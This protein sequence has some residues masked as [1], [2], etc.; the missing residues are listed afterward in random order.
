M[1]IQIRVWANTS[2]RSTLVSPAIAPM[3]INN[4]AH[5]KPTSNMAVVKGEGVSNLV[6]DTIPVK[7]PA[8]RI[9]RTEEIQRDP[10]APRGKSF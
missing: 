10:M 6:Y 5:R 2:A 4:D 7:I 8:T 1:D 9:Y 3:D